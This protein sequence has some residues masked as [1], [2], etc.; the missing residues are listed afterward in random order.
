MSTIGA[1]ALRSIDR[2]LCDAASLFDDEISSEERQ[3]MLS[4]ALS[5]LDE[6]EIVSLLDGVSKL[7]QVLKALENH[8]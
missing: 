1:E 4:T 6:S 8:Q 5:Y 2:S 3:S 7:L